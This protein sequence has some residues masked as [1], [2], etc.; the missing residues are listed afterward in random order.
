MGRLTD[1]EM[2]EIFTAT[3]ALETEHEVLGYLSFIANEFQ[4]LVN[5]Y[6]TD[7]S[8]QDLHLSPGYFKGFFTLSMAV[9]RARAFFPTI[10]RTTSEQQGGGRIVMSDEY[11][12]ILH[13]HGQY[14]HHTDAYIVGTRDALLALKTAINA[15]L[16]N[17]VG[18]ANSYCSDGEG[19]SI[20]VIEISEESMKR[21]AVPY[22][23]DYAAESSDSKAVSWP[24]DFI[25]ERWSERNAAAVAAERSVS[26]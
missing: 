16:N 9:N 6:Q 17:D 25:K 18:S 13:I 24:W 12:G 23:A 8:V 4:H 14:A 7:A 19:F 11:K 21:A 22:S 20:Y 5:N 3:Y 1:Q 2:S 15:A 26:E 10:K